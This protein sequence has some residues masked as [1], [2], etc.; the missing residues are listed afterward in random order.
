MVQGGGVP[1]NPS[2]EEENS[3]GEFGL[4]PTTN[5]NLVCWNCRG[6]GGPRKREFLSRFL[7]ATRVSIAFVV[8]TKCSQQKSDL[9]L[10][11]QPLPNFE[12]VPAIGRSGGLWLLWD[13]NVNVTVMF[14]SRNVIHARVQQ[15]HQP[16]WSLVCV[17]GDAAHTRNK[18]IWETIKQIVDREG[19]V[20]V[21]GDFNAIADMQEKYGGNPNNN[22]NNRIFKDFL[23]DTGLMDLGF[24]GP[25]YTWTNGKDTMTEIFQ[26]LDRIVVTTSWSQQFPQAYVNHLPR[27][28]SDHAAILLRAH[29]K[30]QSQSKFKIEK[31]WFNHEGFQQACET[32]WNE[33][34]DKQ[35]PERA[36]ALR[37]HI[38]QWVKTVQNPQTWLNEIQNRRLIMQSLHPSLQNRDEENRVLEEYYKAENDLS[39]YWRQRSRLQWNTEGDRNTAFFHVVATSRRRRNQITHIESDTGEIIT[40]EAGI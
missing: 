22:S 27:V 9:F 5:M 17:Y 26:R 35:W 21:M 7:R 34:S 23:F 36:A 24:K 6:I 38:T 10:Q 2:K 12:C 15:P 28:H 31:W 16:G 19:T 40:T 20:C 30:P 1:P 18:V 3:G 14:K 39:D 32:R 37:E 25:A 8:E 33:T 29:G 13:H 4:A 11:N